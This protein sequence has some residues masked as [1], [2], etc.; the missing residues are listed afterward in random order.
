MSS[1][2]Y[3]FSVLTC[4]LEIGVIYVS[5]WN[6]LTG[7]F[8]QLSIAQVKAEMDK[9][10]QWLTPFAT[11]TTKYDNTIFLCPCQPSGLICYLNFF[12]FK[13]LLFK[14]KNKHLTAQKVT[15][16]GKGLVML[17]IEKSIFEILI[18]YVT[19]INVE[20]NI[21]FIYQRCKHVLYTCL[22]LIQIISLIQTE[23]DRPI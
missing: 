20:N 12:S 10:L 15:L 9:I 11:N 16:D 17:F 19:H 4:Y 8:V 23:S 1:K 2:R 5:C 14:L 22:F 21:I 7:N 13:N 6:M 18:N 3:V